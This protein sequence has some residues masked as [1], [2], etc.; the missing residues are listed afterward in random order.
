[1]VVIS[2][3][4]VDPDGSLLA[5]IA[6]RFR[7]GRGPLTPKQACCLRVAAELVPKQSRAQ[8]D[9]Y[10]AG[11]AETGDFWPLAE[12]PEWVRFMISPMWLHYFLDVFVDIGDRIDDGLAPYPR[13]MAERVALWIA[14]RQA[15]KVGPALKGSIVYDALNGLIGTKTPARS[16]DRNW[17]RAQVKLFGGDF[18]FLRIWSAEF[19]HVGIVGGLAHSDPVGLRLRRFH[20][21]Y[22]WDT[23][24]GV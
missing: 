6:D 19:D 23:Y 13:T 4:F 14:L 2:E 16:T 12:L 5:V 20:P 9:G 3:S 24:I 7:G 22:W 11:R 17:N 8:W 1:M 21:Y 10:V 18:D 15:R